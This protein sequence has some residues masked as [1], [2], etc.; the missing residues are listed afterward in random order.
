MSLRSMTFVTTRPNRCKHLWPSLL[1]KLIILISLT[2]CIA[3][4]TAG[5]R[6][7][8]PSSWEEGLGVVEKNTVITYFYRSSIVCSATTPH[9]SFPKEGTT[10]G[11]RPL[12]GQ[13]WSSAPAAGPVSSLSVT[14]NSLDCSRR[15]KRR[16]ST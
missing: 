16:N 6:P 7:V 4:P 1:Q 12:F 13:T 15:K 3:A 8:V 11:A 10:L 9:P 14:E 2:G 5:C